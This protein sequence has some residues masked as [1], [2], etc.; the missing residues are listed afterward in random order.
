MNTKIAFFSLYVHFCC[1]FWSFT[2]RASCPWKI[3]ILICMLQSENYKNQDFLY[4][5]MS[6]CTNVEK[7]LHMVK[8]YTALYIIIGSYTRIARTSNKTYYS[9]NVVICYCCLVAFWGI[10]QK[11]PFTIHFCSFKIRNFI[12]KPKK[13]HGDSNTILLYI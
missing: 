3:K 13:P 1:R 8:L 12:S 7:L 6:H 5:I 4:S 11:T 9:I 2:A 10:Y